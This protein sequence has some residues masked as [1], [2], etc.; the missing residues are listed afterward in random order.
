MAARG[1]ADTEGRAS[2]RATLD[3][4]RRRRAEQAF[5]TLPERYLGAEPDFDATFQIRL[6]DVGRTWQV[7]AVGARC[8]VRPTPS[9]D[10]DVVI[11]TDSAA[12]LA[13]REGR[14]SGLDAFAQRRLYARGNLDLALGFE[15]LFRLPGGRPPLLAVSTV[16]IG[17]ASVSTLIAGSGPEQVVCLHGLGSN[18]AS[19]FETISALTPEHTVHAIDLPGFGASSKPARA[20]YD[21]AWFAGCVLGY[22]DATAIDRAHVIGN[23]MGGRVAIELALRNPERV[24]TLSL[25]APSVAFRRRRELAPLVR[26][27]RP[28]IAA[29]PHPMRAAQV[30]ETLWSLFARPERLDPAAADIVADGFCE[31]YRSRSGR[32]AFYA[33]ARSIYLDPPHGERGFWTRLAGLE[34]PSLFVWG[35]QDRLVPAGFARHVAEALPQARQEILTECGHVPQV[36]LPER[37]NAMI[38]GLI[39]AHPSTATEAADPRPAPAPGRGRG[40]RMGAWPIRRQSRSARAATEAATPG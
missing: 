12:W 9:R 40:N 39:E 27:L 10:P 31:T 7:R 6:G 4:Q 25:L 8:E 19:F 32:V 16:E 24:A 36:E 14:L 26:L 18:K 13:L 11:G 17:G 33:A 1:S 23:S 3:E 38:R 5:A 2:G 34:P 22:L 21:A 15:G 35:D 30:R 20:A 28:E 29:F 37:T